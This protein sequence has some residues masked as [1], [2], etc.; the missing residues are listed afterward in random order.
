[1]LAFLHGF[2]R[3]RRVIHYPADSIRRQEKSTRCE[4]SDPANGRAEGPVFCKHPGKTRGV[5]GAGEFREFEP[6]GDPAKKHFSPWPGPKKQS[7][8]KP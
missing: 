4:L 8:L 2:F 7:I 1:M 6:I 3:Q 5:A